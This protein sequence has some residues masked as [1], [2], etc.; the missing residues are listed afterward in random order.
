MANANE[1]T[2]SMGIRLLK[3]GQKGLI[4]ALFSRFG[5]IL[6]LFLVQVAILFS[7]FMWFRDLQPYI[8]A[9]MTTFSVVMV[10]YLLN[11]RFDPTA[12]ITWLVIIMLMPVFGAF[13]LWFTKSEIGHRLIKG[14]VDQIAGAAKDYIPQNPEVIQRLEQEN[15]GVRALVRYVGRSGCHPVFDDTAV[16]YFPVG[17]KKWEEM[18][19]QLERAQRYIFL[20]YFIVDEGLMW[21]KVLEILARK[22]AEGVEV[23]LM[24]DGFCEFTTLSH[25]YPE[26][27]KKLGIKCKL[28]APLTPFVSTHYNYRDHRKIL[29]I[30]GH[31]AFTGGVNLADEYIN[32]KKKHGHWKD[33]AVMLQGQ[34]ARSFALMFLEMWGIEEKELEFDRFLSDIPVGVREAKEQPGYVMP[35]G[36]CPLDEERVGERVYMDILNR[37]HRYVHIM[38]PYLIIDHELTTAL[39]FA[40]KRGVDVKLILPAVPDKKTVFALTRSCYRELIAGGVE[41]YEYEPGFVHAKSFVSDGVTAVTGSINLDYR[42][43]Y[44]HFECAALLY[45]CPAV[46]DVERDFQETLAKCHAVTLE[47]CRTARLSQKLTGLLLRPLAPLM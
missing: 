29:V 21:G 31:T 34:A 38:T 26:K 5:V 18:L 3:K 46:A 45:R 13:L 6:L 30:D 41:I 19:R 36:D 24:I 47:E 4:H 37:A 8:S 1:E 44:L 23:R 42:S 15:P 12:K 28:F 25:N 32:Y 33:T 7:V 10:L 43:L 40:A 9:L 35:Y 14:R 17:E 11:S 20:E 27:L 39:T 22:A 16:T 2:Q